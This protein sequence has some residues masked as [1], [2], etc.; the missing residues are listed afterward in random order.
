MVKT[1]SD[2]DATAAGESHHR[3]PRSIS[4]FALSK[5]RL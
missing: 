5:V 1:I 4:G 2:A 3:P